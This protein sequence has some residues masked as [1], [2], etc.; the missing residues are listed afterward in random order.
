[1][2][3]V[4]L[5]SSVYLVCRILY[6]VDIAGILGIPAILFLHKILH[7]LSVIFDEVRTEITR[8]TFKV[9]LGLSGRPF[10]F[11]VFLYG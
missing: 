5:F 10:C 6:I 11:L 3:G 7:T 2:T 4:F 8:Y 9:P 1:M